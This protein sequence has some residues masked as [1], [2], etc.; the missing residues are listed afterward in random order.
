MKK[1]T[2]EQLEEKVF[3]MDIYEPRD[4]YITR[5]DLINWAIREFAGKGEFVFQYFDR[6]KYSIIIAPI[7]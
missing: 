1:F 5:E 7:E 6:K 4:R 2:K 3:E